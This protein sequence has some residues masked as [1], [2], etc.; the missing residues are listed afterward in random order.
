MDSNISIPVTE[1][2]NGPDDN[3]EVKVEQKFSAINDQEAADNV[4]EEPV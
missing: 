1:F 4:D 2:L 3:K